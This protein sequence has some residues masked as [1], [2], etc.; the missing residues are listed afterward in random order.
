MKI[1]LPWRTSTQGKQ[2]TIYW[3]SKFASGWIFIEKKN[4]HEL[5]W[6][7]AP[8]PTI[9]NICKNI[10]TIII[11]INIITIIIAII[12]ARSKRENFLKFKHDIRHVDHARKNQIPW[13]QSTFFPCSLW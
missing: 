12:I 13:N 9:A 3:Y 5:T 11:I 8:F 7:N 2:T 6:A 10:I 4:I 1:L